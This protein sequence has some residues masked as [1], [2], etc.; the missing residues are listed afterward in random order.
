MPGTSQSDT[1]FGLVGGMHL[2]IPA[3]D[4]PLVG[5]TYRYND[6]TRDA[7]KTSE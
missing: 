1:S 3:L 4:P 5:T 2:V 7:V 6:C